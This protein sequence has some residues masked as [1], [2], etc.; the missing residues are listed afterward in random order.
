M[1]GQIAEKHR[2]TSIKNV[3]KYLAEVH[4]IINLKSRICAE[5]FNGYTLTESIL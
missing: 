2:K 5:V 3:C 1:L 4:F